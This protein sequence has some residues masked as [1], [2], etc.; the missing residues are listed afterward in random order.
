MTSISASASTSSSLPSM[1]AATCKS[2]F[3]FTNASFRPQYSSPEVDTIFTTLTGD[4]TGDDIE[5]SKMLGDQSGEQST[6]DAPRFPCPQCPASYKR[7]GGLVRHQ[8]E[9]HD[10]PKFLCP[11]DKCPRGI[12]GEGFGRMHHLVT[13]LT[14]HKHGMGKIE[15]MFLARQFNKPK[16][17]ARHVQ[18]QGSGKQRK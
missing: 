4:D 8:S 9:K 11:I 3:F 5:H 1:M 14:T 15:A 6:P 7:A 16:S 17:K 18:Q 10:P 12:E 2:F 13:H